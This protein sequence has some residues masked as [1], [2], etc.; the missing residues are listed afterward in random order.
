MAEE[1]VLMEIVSRPHGRNLVKWAA[2]KPDVLVLSADL[3]GSC[4]ADGFRDAYPRRFISCGI[5]E[6]NMLSVAGGLCREGFIPLVHTFAVFICRRAFDQVAMSVAYPNLPVKMFGFLPGITTP[7][8]ATHQ[9]IDDVALMRSL[10]NMTV[11]ETGDATEV[12]SVLDL[13]YSID[14][15]VYV[16]MLRGDVPRLFPTDEP[17]RADHPRILSLGDEVTVFSSGIC[18]EEVLRASAVLKAR[19]VSITHVL[20]STLKPF[21]SGLIDQ[22][23][24]AGS[25]GIV[26]VENHLVDG[27]LGTAVASRCASTG[28][29]RPLVRLG[30]QDTW[31]HGAGRAALMREHGFDA[32]ALVNAVQDLIGAN[33]SISLADLGAVRV[34]PVHSVAKAEAL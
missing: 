31:S 13:A 26:T 12:E 24:R 19:G 30:L 1:G 18:T 4:E 21:A 2:D 6:Q 8:G 17:I 14:G 34:E 23:I 3:T 11:L 7:G 5:A 16:R 9:A 20:I 32:M 27:G 33:L 22:A 10:P 15:P 28:V 25:R 29:G